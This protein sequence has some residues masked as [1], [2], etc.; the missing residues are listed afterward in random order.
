M[1]ALL[2]L[3]RLPIATI[4]DLL[5]DVD[6]ADPDIHQVLGRALTRAPATIAGEDSHQSTVARARVDE[7]V[8]ARGWLVG[9]DSP[10]R[11]TI[12]DV[13]VAFQQ[14]GGALKSPARI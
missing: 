5:A 7:L 1:R 2:E 6:S 10:A 14:L 13:L 3:G 11:R 4:K 8:A 12:A 9:P